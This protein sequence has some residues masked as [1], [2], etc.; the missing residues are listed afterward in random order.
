M[1]IFFIA[2]ALIIFG[3]SQTQARSIE[4]SS[5]IKLFGVGENGALTGKVVVGQ[6]HYGHQTLRFDLFQDT[7]NN[8]GP[9]SGTYRRQCF[10]MLPPQLILKFAGSYRLGNSDVCGG[11]MFVYV[12]SVTAEYYQQAILCGFDP[13]NQSLTL[14]VMNSN[15][16]VRKLHFVSRPKIL[17]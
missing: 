3:Q 7:C 11:S 17:N 15:G 14:Q 9:S 8:L 1:K 4:I 10:V 13:Y 12:D 2:M 5:D 16:V 6:I